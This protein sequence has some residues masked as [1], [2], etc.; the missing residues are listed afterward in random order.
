MERC[1]TLPRV[2]VTQKV[3]C[4]SLIHMQLRFSNLF[5]DRLLLEVWGLLLLSTT[6]GGEVEKLVEHNWSPF[7]VKI[8]LA[9][10][11]DSQGSG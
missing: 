7:F 10:L 6:V 3:Y 9:S 8:M 1:R 5:A 11:M 2:Y 4:H